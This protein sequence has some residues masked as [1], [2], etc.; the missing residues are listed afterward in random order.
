[1]EGS[2]MNDKPKPTLV[3]RCSERGHKLVVVTYENGQPIGTAQAVGYSMADLVGDPRTH[4]DVVPTRFILNAITTAN[5]N[6]LV[7]C[8]CGIRSVDLVEIRTRVRDGVTGKVLATEGL[9]PY[10][11]H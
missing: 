3:Y 11:G 6:V 4:K 1:M 5:F 8:A 7:G 10:G 2:G 9:H